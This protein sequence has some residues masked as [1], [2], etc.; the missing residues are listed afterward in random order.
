M[1]PR[2]TSGTA[3][4]P[5][6]ERVG[7]VPFLPPSHLRNRSLDRVV[8]VSGQS[9]VAAAGQLLLTTH[10]LVRSTPPLD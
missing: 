2:T 9:V 7:E 6:V 10:T 3:L 4:I 8:A 1:C 5:P